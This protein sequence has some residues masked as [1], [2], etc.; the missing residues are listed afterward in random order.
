MLLFLCSCC[1]A[2][3]KVALNMSS[4]LRTSWILKLEFQKTSSDELLCL[5]EK[6]L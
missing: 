4:E 6:I 2:F 1:N 3:T 5:K